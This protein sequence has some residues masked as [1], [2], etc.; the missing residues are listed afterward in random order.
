MF[1][2]LVILFLKRLKILLQFNI[3]YY[4]ILFLAIV[5]CLVFNCF[6]SSNDVISFENSEFVITNFYKSSY[7][8][9]IDLKGNERFVGYL[10][11]DS[12][13]SDNFFNTYNIGDKVFIYG[14][15]RNISNNTVPNTFNYKKYLKNNNISGV[16]NVKSLTKVSNSINIFYRI[17]DLM[18]K[19]SF[20]LKKSYSYI[21]SL[22]FGVNDYIDDQVLESYRS[23]GISHL[24]AISGLHISFFISFISLFFDK[25]KVKSI[26]KSVFIVLFLLFYLFL[27]NFSISIIRAAFF[28]ILVMFNKML[29]LNISNINLFLLTLSFCLFINPLA[30]N[31]LGFKYSFVITFFLLKYSNYINRGSTLLKMFKVSFISFVVSYPITIN[32]FYSINFLS[33]FYNLFFVPFLSFIIFPFVILSYIFPFLDSVLYLLINFLELSVRLLEYI[34]IFKIDMCKINALI[35]FLYFVVI[36]KMFNALYRNK[37]YYLFCA[38][39]SAFLF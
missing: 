12:N 7:G 17:K 20:S 11:C 14:E 30:I 33:P 10:Y 39:F 1:L 4:F 15:L 29:K 32:G 25:F 36:C 19:R 13:K 31:N 28:N 9:K 27:T 37:Y 18:I 3:F 34:D 24:F 35:C 21:N 22:I 16:I 26:I 38:L 6:F 8:I 2:E 5:F 23:I